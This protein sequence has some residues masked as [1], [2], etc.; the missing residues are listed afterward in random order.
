MYI[1]KEA[2]AQAL[3]TIRHVCITFFI[4]RSLLRVYLFTLT[5]KYII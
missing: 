3:F 5:C 4:K 1:Y 2:V